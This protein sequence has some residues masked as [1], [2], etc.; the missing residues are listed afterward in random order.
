MERGK[1]EGELVKRRRFEGN[2][3]SVYIHESLHLVLRN[4]LYTFS[5]A[6]ML[7]ITGLFVLR[8][9]LICG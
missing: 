5:A 2:K 9:L 7:Y 3:G 1:R 8:S 4:V 6:N